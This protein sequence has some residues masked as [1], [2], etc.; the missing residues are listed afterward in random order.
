MVIK[1]KL[2]VVFQW[3]NIL[4]FCICFLSYLSYKLWHYILLGTKKGGLG[5][6]LGK[7]GKGKG[8][9]PLALDRQTQP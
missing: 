2:Q 6:A 7:R 4:V 5:E 3:L 9:K 1:N 8:A